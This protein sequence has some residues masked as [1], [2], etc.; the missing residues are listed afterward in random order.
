MPICA[1]LT[2][3]VVDERAYVA[4]LIY[5]RAMD[6]EQRLALE[7][8]IEVDPE[9]ASTYLVLADWLQEHDD[10]RGELIIAANGT[11]EESKGRATMLQRQLGPPPLRHGQQSWFSGFVRGLTGI[12]DEDDAQL[13]E[14]YL[15]HPSLRFATSLSFDLAGSLHDDRQWLIELLVRHAR[16]TW[17]VLKIRSYRR[18]GNDPACGDLDLAPLWS[19]APWTHVHVIG[20]FLSPG[21]LASSTLARLE[22][23]GYVDRNDLAPLLAMSAPNLVE[24]ALHDIDPVFGSQLVGSPLAARLTALTLPFTAARYTTVVAA[25]IPTVK[26]LPADEDRYEQIG[27]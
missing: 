15:E 12:V 11:D 9:Q 1:S 7:A 20:R 23:D 5:S 13:V 27:E 6:D 24:L 22:L 2:Q 8:A 26:F 14:S 21:G 25:A 18:G 10:P 4:R 16:P 19:A 3:Q 17:R